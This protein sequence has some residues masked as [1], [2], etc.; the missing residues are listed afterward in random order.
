MAILDCGRIVRTGSTEA[1]REEVK[2]I[3]LP[4]DFAIANQKPDGLLD[5]RRFDDRLA[6]TTDKAMD[7]IHKLSANGVSFDVVDL[8]LDE[9]FEAFVI[10]RTQDWPSQSIQ[11]V[12]SV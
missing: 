6:I 8:R 2:Q 3:L 7:Y 4:M 1:I 9:I 10:G 12:V 5:V 11:G